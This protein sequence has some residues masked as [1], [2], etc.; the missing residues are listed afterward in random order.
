[1][2]ESSENES[3]IVVIEALQCREKH[4]YGRCKHIKKVTVFQKKMNVDIIAN[5]EL[6]S[7]RANFENS[8]MPLY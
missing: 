2:V 8:G 7:L 5:Y 6:F 3:M 4:R 1:M